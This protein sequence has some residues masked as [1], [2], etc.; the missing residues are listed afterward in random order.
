M[1]SELW[2]SALVSPLREMRRLQDEVNRV[3]RDLVP[4]TAAEVEHPPVNV[5]TSDEG[6][7]LVAELPGLTPDGIDVSLHGHELVIQGE[8]VP[9]EGLEGARVWR[10]E[11][12]TG[13]FSRTVALPFRVDAD[14]IDARYAHG[15][16][17]VVL[18][19][20]AEERPVRIQVKNA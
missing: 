8:R 12:P 10:R 3:F 5:W 20:V 4:A 7:V 2:S 17:E 15:V 6:L 9:E 11:R 16:L 14:R 18:P 19:R 1:Q 13:R